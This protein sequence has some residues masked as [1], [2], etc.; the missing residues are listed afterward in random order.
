[1]WHSTEQVEKNAKLDDLRKELNAQIDKALGMGM[2][3][4]HIDNHMGSLYG[5]RTGRFTMLNM[6]LK[7]MG[8]RGY[9]FRLYEKTD[10]RLVPAGTPAPIY[11]ISGAMTKLLAKIHKV[12][13]PDYLLFPDWN[14]ELSTNGYE[15]Y[16]KTILDLWTNIPDGVT[17]TFLHPAYETD[18][19]KSITGNWFQRVWEYTPS[20]RS[21]A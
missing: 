10:K 15:H 2:K 3:P 6:T 14:R 18:E 20:R 5:N 1:M 8:K 17:E 7:E 19:L 12:T 16:R 21:S 4:S 11:M 9:A 13:L